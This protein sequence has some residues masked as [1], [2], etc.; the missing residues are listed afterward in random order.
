MHRRG[1]VFLVT[2]RGG[3]FHARWISPVAIFPCAGIR[4]ELSE[5]A[6]AEAFEKGDPRKVKRLHREDHLSKEEYWVRG[7]GWSLA[8]S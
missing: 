8:Y 7:S 4:D 1:A 5:K 6:L 2:R 3:D